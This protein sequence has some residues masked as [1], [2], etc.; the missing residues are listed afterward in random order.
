MLGIDSSLAVYLLVYIL[1]ISFH[2]LLTSSVEKLA[3]ILIALLNEICNFS[4]IFL[5]ILVFAQSCVSG[6]FH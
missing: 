2:C 3:V 6:R 5:I 4:V 1:K